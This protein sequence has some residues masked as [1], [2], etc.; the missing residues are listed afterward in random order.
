MLK[1]NQLLVPVS[2]SFVREGFSF[3][4]RIFVAGNKR[5]V[6]QKVCNECPPILSACVAGC[7]NSVL[8]RVGN[9][10]LPA[11]PAT[12]SVSTAPSHLPLKGKAFYLQRGERLPLSGEAV[13]V[14]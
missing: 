8:L 4:L 5:N 3:L 11:L 12:S 10:C 14:S 1:K 9:V 7:K 6:L 2:A 13:S